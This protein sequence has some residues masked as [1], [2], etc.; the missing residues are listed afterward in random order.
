MVAC[1]GVKDS[2]SRITPSKI[3]FCSMTGDSAGI[4][5]FELKANNDI[6]IVHRQWF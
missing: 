4:A 6:L 2:A 5:Y 1:N 3:V